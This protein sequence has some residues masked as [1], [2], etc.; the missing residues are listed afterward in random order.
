MQPGHSPRNDLRW[1]EDGAGLLVSY[2]AVLERASRSQHSEPVLACLLMPRPLVMGLSSKETAASVPARGA[3][4][5]L[6][7]VLRIV[8]GLQV[9]TTT[10][11][12]A[13]SILLRL[14]RARE[15]HF[16]VPPSLWTL[17]HHDIAA[18]E[19]TSLWGRRRVESRYSNIQ[20]AIATRTL[21]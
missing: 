5:V 19:G 21:D 6:L 8:A 20:H 11:D 7:E 15:V 3:A 16:R 14:Y 1:V 18:R 4:Q 2:G 13:P 12:E 17:R 10:G 9:G